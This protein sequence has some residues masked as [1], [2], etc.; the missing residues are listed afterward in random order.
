MNAPSPKDR[1]IVALDFADVEEARALVGA[2]QDRVRIYKI[3]FEL[4]LSGG[5]ALARS[6]AAEGYDVF[7]D[8]K[9]L[10]IAHTVE[11]ATAAAGRLGVRFLTV[12]GHD[13]KTLDAAVRGREAARAE[14]GAAGP[15]L[16]LL[17]VTVLTSL[18]KADL[19]EQG[20][21]MAPEQLVLHR[22]RMA[23]DAGFD[24]VI[25]SGREARPIREAVGADFLI[26]TPGIRPAGAPRGDQV[27][28]MGPA[29]ALAAGA[30]MLVVGRPI[31]RA[32]NP[33][34]AA[35]AL[36]AEIADAD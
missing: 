16:R 17:A 10:D 25:A 12:H 7:L 21:E 8:M 20:V 11:H 1:L 15:G 24:G 6:L 3:G 13:R 26:V 4:A 19:L 32:A 27:R 23:A 14:R 36:L 34:A 2:L 22:A 35:D 18:G 5:L 29:E 31:T 30:D 28:V 9:L 33:A